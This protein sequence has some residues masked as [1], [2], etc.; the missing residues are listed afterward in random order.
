MCLRVLLLDSPSVVPVRQI[1]H[2]LGDPLGSR[3]VEVGPRFQLVGF[4]FGVE[5]IHATRDTRAI[6]NRSQRKQQQAC[7]DRCQAPPC[8]SSVC[9]VS[10][11]R[12]PG[13]YRKRV[14]GPNGLLC[15]RPRPTN[16]IEPT[17][18]CC[19]IVPGTYIRAE[20]NNNAAGLC[21]GGAL[22]NGIDYSW[23]IGERYIHSII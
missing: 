14:I 4:R 11:Q 9:Q 10:K 18:Y 17:S 1:V 3:H 8:M 15:K 13:R 12:I 20:R 23:S 5:R 2:R 6:R 22:R 21:W 7:R 19:N 16:V